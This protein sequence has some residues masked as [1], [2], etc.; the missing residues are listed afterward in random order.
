VK[1]GSGNLVAHAPVARNARGQPGNN[2]AQENEQQHDQAHRSAVDRL[3]RS[4]G[5]GTLRQEMGEI[6]GCRL[7]HGG[8]TL[9]PFRRLLN[10]N[11]SIVMVGLVPTIQPAAC[12]VACREVDPRDEPE[13]D[14]DGVGLRVQFRPTK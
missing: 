9:G 4:H 7:A 2:A 13:D 14:S 5:D 1:I 6:A 11:L 12:S 3:R 8:R 10:R